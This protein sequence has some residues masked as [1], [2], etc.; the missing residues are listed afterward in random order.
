MAVTD[1][2]ATIDSNFE[3]ISMALKH[4]QN[5]INIYVRLKEIDAEVMADKDGVQFTAIPADAKKS[6]RDCWLLIQSFI[7]A[8]EADSSIMDM[9]N[10]KPAL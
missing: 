1:D 2:F 10:S 4:R 8:I 7:T 6:L 3:Q 9:I 5:F